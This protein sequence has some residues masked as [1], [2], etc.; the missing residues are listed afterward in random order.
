[1][2]VEKLQASHLGIDTLSDT[3][4]LSNDSNDVAER[5]GET[6]LLKSTRNT[7]GR[8]SNGGSK[9]NVNEAREVGGSRSNTIQGAVLEI[10]NDDCRALNF[11]ALTKNEPFSQLLYCL[12]VYPLT[13]NLSI[14][15]NLFMRVELRKDDVDIRK[16]ALEVIYRKDRGVSFQKWVH[17]QVAVGA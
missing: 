7:T 16:H 3:G 5:F 17:T 12:F 4:S 1:M 14:K 6:G 2:E 10:G 15:C 11:R 9:W 13:V 8:T